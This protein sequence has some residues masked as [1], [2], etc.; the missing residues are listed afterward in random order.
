MDPTPT[1]TGAPVEAPSPSPSS[2]PE[3]TATP[4]VTV[5]ATETSTVT[6]TAPPSVQDVRMDEGQ[7]Y[8]LFLPL[9]VV[10]FFVAARMALLS[11]NNSVGR[12]H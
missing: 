3:E 11:F 8:G 12:R 4:T 5:T 9:L 10:V 7:F 1:E 2:S 6:V